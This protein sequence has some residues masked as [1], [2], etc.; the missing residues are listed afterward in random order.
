MAKFRLT[1]SQLNVDGF[2]VLTSGG[3]L[4]R[5]MA[6]PICLWMHRRYLDDRDPLPIG[7][8]KDVKIEGDDIVGEPLL[9]EKDEFAVRIKNKVDQN[10]IRMASIG[11]RIIKISED[12]KDLLPGQIRP[13]VTEWEL[14]EGSLVDIGRNQHALRLYDDNYQELKS[15]EVFSTLL[16]E[17][18]AEDKKELLPKLQSMKSIALKLGLS[19]SASEAEICT[20]I[21][22][23]AAAKNT[24][25]ETLADI[26]KKKAEELVDVAVGQGKITADKK[27]HFLKLAMADFEST[28]EVLSAMHSQ[29]KPGDLITP[30][31]KHVAETEDPKIEKFSDLVK[32]GREELEK[33]K[34]ENLDQYAKLYKAEYGIDLSIEKE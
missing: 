13:T 19:E 28:F 34:T 27:E 24:A 33:F 2:R 4:D 1:N 9:D 11:I 32:K 12:P 21:E 17:L 18:S 29:K 25:I 10:I 22:T 15:E 26:S 30:S 8:W 31:T 14:V 20:A 5:F 16:A 23:L 7:Q 3:R 6:N